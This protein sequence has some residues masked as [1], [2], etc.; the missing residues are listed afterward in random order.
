MATS[1]DG[2]SRNLNSWPAWQMGMLR[3]DAQW[4]AMMRYD[5]LC[6][7]TRW[8][9]TATICGKLS[10]ASQMTDPEFAFPKSQTLSGPQNALRI[11][12]DCFLMF[13]YVSLRYSLSIPELLSRW[14]QIGQMMVRILVLLSI[15]FGREYELWT[16]ER[17]V[18]VCSHCALSIPRTI[19]CAVWQARF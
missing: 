4:C 9:I 2:N 17:D 3:N 16:P 12:P 6:T 11:L 5:A 1:R 7:C 18:H 8:M 14:F 10:A 15:G 13:C 19:S